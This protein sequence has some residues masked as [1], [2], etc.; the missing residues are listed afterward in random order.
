MQTILWIH[1]RIVLSTSNNLKKSLSNGFSLEPLCY[2]QVIVLMVDS[3]VVDLDPGSDAF[4]IPG[5]GS[6]IQ[7]RFIPDLGSRISDPRSQTHIF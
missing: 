4:L 6:G 2:L 5:P 1:L 3:S 7:N